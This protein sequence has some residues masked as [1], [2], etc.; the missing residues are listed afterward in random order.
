[1]PTRRGVLTATAIASTST[2]GCLATFSSDEVTGTIQA[3]TRT[4]IANSFEVQLVGFEPNTSVT[5]EAT[6][7]DTRDATYTGSWSLQTDAQG[8]AT[9]TSA[10]ITNQRPPSKWYGAESGTNIVNR[11]PAEMF[12]QSLAPTGS[13]TPANFVI[14]EQNTVELT[15]AVPS[16]FLGQSS[17]QATST[18]VYIDPALQQRSVGAE[19]LVGQ[20]YLPATAGPHPGVL[21]LHGSEAFVLD[22]LSRLLA[23]QGY[24]TLALQYFDAPGL[25]DSVNEVPL[26]YFDRA[27]RWLIDQEEI[28]DGHIGL[29]GFSRGVEAALLSGAAYD[30]PAT[31]VGYSGG[32][33]AVQ[34]T[35]GVPPVRFTGQ[36][37]W[38]RNGTPVAPAEAVETAFSTVQDVYDGNYAIEEGVQSVLSEISVRT[39]K[40]ALVPVEDVDGPILL[41]AGVDDQQW[42]STLLAALTVRRLRQRGYS[43][44]YGLR[45]YRNAGHLFQYPYRNYTGSPTSEGN[46]GTPIANARAAADSWP[47]VLAFLDHG[48]RQA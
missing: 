28:M 47:S 42:P 18:R 24:A 33:V 25:P 31:V 14:N 12:L 20:L 27:I 13:P 22:E 30:G 45:T 10:E 4:T 44:P 21:A 41:L 19:G 17:A 5:L 23:T 2:A 46:G 35:V 37:A 34:G 32:G 36:A 11:F 3:P 29:V 7:T 15:F 40:Q 1:M 6:A 48:L 26:E 39:L 38:T 16:G 8:A 9:L 43:H